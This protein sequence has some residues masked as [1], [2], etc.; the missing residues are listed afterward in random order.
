MLKKFYTGS[1]RQA[2]KEADLICIIMNKKELVKTRCAVC[3]IDDWLYIC[4]K[5]IGKDKYIVYF[6]R[7]R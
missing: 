4:D 5:K 2:L 6:D 3:G 1:K 7:M